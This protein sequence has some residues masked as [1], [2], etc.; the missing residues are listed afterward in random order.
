MLQYVKHVGKYLLR[1]EYRLSEK[2]A[3]KL[4]LI[5]RQPRFTVIQTDIFPSPLWMV[6]SASFV[7]IYSEIFKQE[8]YKFKTSNA[9]P[10]ILDCGANIGLSTLYFKDLFPDA[11]VVAFEP[12]TKV[13]EIL[14]KNVQ[15]FRLTNVSLLNKAVWHSE[16]KLQFYAEG[17]DGG[18]ITNDIKEANVVEIETVRLKDF[19]NRPVDMLKI[20]IEGAETQVLED[21]ADVL[22]YIDK[23]FIEYHSFVNQEQTLDK[24]LKIIKEA[25]FTYYINQVGIVSQSPFYEKKA[26]LG[27]DNQLNIFADRVK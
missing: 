17:A 18:R 6:D 12:D 3:K 4:Q 22:S 14:A 26:F 19:I 15:S 24:I 23:I 20:D 10:Y 21:I 7:F 2:E 8:I 1:P 5:K 13:F 11:E 16:T 25:G 27:M 9:K